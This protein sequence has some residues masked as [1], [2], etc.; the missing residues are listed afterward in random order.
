M[1][2]DPAAAWTVGSA[3][4]A[5]SAGITAAMVP[6]ERITTAICSQMLPSRATTATGRMTTLF[7]DPST[8]VHQPIHPVSSISHHR[9]PLFIRNSPHGYRRVFARPPFR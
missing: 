7:S 3:G 5:W 6:S 2:T 1:S 9:L 8:V 4:S